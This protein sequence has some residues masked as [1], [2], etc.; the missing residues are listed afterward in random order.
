MH[1]R[2]CSHQGNRDKL[3]SMKDV[4]QRDAWGEDSGE[5]EATRM[6]T[7]TITG[8]MVLSSHKTATLRTSSATMRFNHDQSYE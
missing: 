3:S 4:T 6:L 7:G 1:V 5:N 2:A 8:K